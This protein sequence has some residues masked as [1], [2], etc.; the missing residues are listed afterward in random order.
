MAKPM[1]DEI[2]RQ[3]I[4]LLSNDARSSNGDIAEQLGLVEGTVR[5]RIKRLQADNVIKIMAIADIRVMAQQANPTMAY[6]GIHAN[7][8]S[9]HQTAKAIAELSFVRFAAIMLGR[10]EILAIS[11]FSSHDEMIECI[12]NQ[13]MPIAGVKHVDTK[14]AIKNIKYD[15]RWGR[16]IEPDVEA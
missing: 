9:L 2:D 11:F 7:L 6:L 16:I 13:I 14:L 5:A 10:Y 4:A 8:D 15:Y 12:N 1:I 3:I